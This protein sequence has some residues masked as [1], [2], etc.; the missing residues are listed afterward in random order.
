MKAMAA[1]RVLECHQLEILAFKSLNLRLIK[2]QK[3]VKA[4][5][6]ALIRSA[7]TIL[8]HFQI[9]TPRMTGKCKL[10]HTNVLCPIPTKLFIPIESLQLFCPPSHN[11]VPASDSTRYSASFC[12]WLEDLPADIVVYCQEE[13]ILCL[14]HQSLIRTVFVLVIKC[15]Q[16]LFEYVIHEC[17]VGSRSISNGSTPDIWKFMMN[18]AYA[19]VRLSPFRLVLLSSSNP[20]TPIIL[21]MLIARLIFVDPV[22]YWL[23]HVR[24]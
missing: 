16:G 3:T 8:S 2:H 19:C 11:A 5:L 15:L 1:A 20:I 9:V 13:R 24:T 21:L 4:H 23:Y 22:V 14:Q 18:L 7:P 17:S 10:E 6:I 12:E